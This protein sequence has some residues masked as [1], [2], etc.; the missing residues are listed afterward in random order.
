MVLDKIPKE[1]P[2]SLCTNQEEVVMDEDKGHKIEKFEGLN[3][4]DANGGSLVC[5]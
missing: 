3:F 5:Y 1:R 2:S 4:R